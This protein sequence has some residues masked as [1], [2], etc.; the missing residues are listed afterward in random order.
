MLKFGI[1]IHSLLYIILL[2]DVFIIRNRW[3]SC[4]YQRAMLYISAVFTVERSVRPSVCPSY[5]IRYCVGTV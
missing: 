1:N 4:F 2:S 5:T 3:S